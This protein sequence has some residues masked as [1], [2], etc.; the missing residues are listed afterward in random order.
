MEA[1]AS[2]QTEP[3][4]EGGPREPAVAAQDGGTSAQEEG[5]PHSSPDEHLLDG[6]P[7]DAS[8]PD[9]EAGQGGEVGPP[10][11]PLILPE[12][13]RTVL[14]DGGVACL[15]TRSDRLELLD[16]N[17]LALEG[18][19]VFRGH[20]RMGD[21]RTTK[22]LFPST[23][24]VVEGTLNFFRNELLVDITA[25]AGL[26]EVGDLSLHH[27]YQLETLSGLEGLRHVRRKLFI[28]SNTSLRS[29]GA[30]DGLETAG[31]EI[32]IGDNP[33]LPAEEIERIQAQVRIVSAD[34][35]VPADAA[36]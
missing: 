22:A 13:E 16:N 1:G 18:C 32:S 17:V 15:A 34:A 35:A 8:P 33:S 14:P 30:L 11:P 24:R 3:V 21:Q 28:G 20:L 12:I 19:T 23:L 26:T 25:L 7:E 36:D 27:N 10:M 2:S 5:V 6:G 9:H 4:P 31:E 29:L